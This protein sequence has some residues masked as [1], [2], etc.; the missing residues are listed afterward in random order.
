MLSF[1]ACSAVYPEASTAIRAVPDHATLEPPPPDDLFFIYFEK[2]A[3]PAKTQGGL[4]WDGGAPDPFAVLT[5]G[6][7]EVLKTPVES[8]TREPKWE[9]QKKE[10][11]R[12]S[13]AQPIYVDLWDSNPVRNHPICHVLVKN[14]EAMRDGADKEL[15][16]D[17]GARIWLHVEPARAVF[18]V[19]LY[20]ETRGSDGVRVTRVAGGS[21]AAR[22]G[23]AAGD[24]I[25]AIQGKKVAEMDSLTVRS[26]MNQHARSG[27]ELDVWF[28]N[29]KR[30]I[31]KLKE[32]PIYPRSGDDLKLKE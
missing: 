27:L 15:W 4:A 14:L 16:C 1:F 5:V 26:M 25:L 24:R 13:V 10:N 8:K 12:I 18:G 2:A 3:I 28:A 6:G 30:H 22:A 17:S 31:V 21:P 20:Y 19:G 23:L 11:H 7:V 32:G 29:G 9:D